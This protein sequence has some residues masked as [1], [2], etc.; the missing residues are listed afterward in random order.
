MLYNVPG[1]RL[2]RLNASTL[3][4]DT[5]ALP[6]SEYPYPVTPATALYDMVD[7]VED[8]FVTCKFVGA[9][10]GLETSLVVNGFVAVQSGA[11]P[12]A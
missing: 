8:R 3:P 12:V 9:A 1:T 10:H 2:E 5:G 11:S 4:T 6:L 7:P